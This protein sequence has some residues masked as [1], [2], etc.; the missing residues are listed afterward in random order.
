MNNSS[1]THIAGVMDG[2]NNEA[3]DMMLVNNATSM[4]YFQG[5]EW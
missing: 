5:G 3:E 4:Q 2:S 1:G